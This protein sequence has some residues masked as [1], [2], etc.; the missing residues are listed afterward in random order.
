MVV[1][2]VLTAVV[3]AV[4]HYRLC[5]P[6]FQCETDLSLYPYLVVFNRLCVALCNCLFLF[7]FHFRLF[8][9]VSN[10]SGLCNDPWDSHGFLLPGS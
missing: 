2:G 9:F 7:C 8:L 6:D 5:W 10:L 4:Q 3:S 1:G